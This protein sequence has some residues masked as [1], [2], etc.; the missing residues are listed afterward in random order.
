MLFAIGEAVTVDGVMTAV[1]NLGGFAAMS[2]VLYTLHTRA[3]VSHERQLDRERIATAEQIKAEREMWSERFDR[4]H[5]LYQKLD[6]KVDDRF[7][8]IDRKLMDI[9]QGREIQNSPEYKE[10]E[11]HHVRRLK[12][13]K[14]ENPSG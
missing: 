11:E 3:L 1:T 14:G 9:Q 5:D 8:R 7:G 13:G 4:L 10:K 2:Y 6:S 12:G